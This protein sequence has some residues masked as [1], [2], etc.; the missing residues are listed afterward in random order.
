[1]YFGMTGLCTGRVSVVGRTGLN[2]DVRAFTFVIVLVTVLG[3]AGV[4]P[5][6]IG[7]NTENVRRFFMG[8]V[9]FPLVV[10]INVNAGLASCTGIFAG[11]TCVIV[12]VT[13]IVNTVVKA[14]VINGLFRFCPMRKVLAT[15]LYVT[16]NNNTNSMRY[17]NTTRHVRLVS[18]TR[19]SSEVNNTVVLIVTDFVF[20]GFLWS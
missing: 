16:G 1:M 20:N 5:R 7:T 11:P 3:V 8:C 15:K 17:L 18:C 9:S 2:F 10:A 14:F 19:V 12:V 6:G 13:A 4:L